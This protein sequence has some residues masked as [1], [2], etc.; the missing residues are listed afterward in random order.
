MPAAAAVRDAT[1]PWWA[2]PTATADDHD[3]RRGGRPAAAYR[4][5]PAGHVPGTLLRPGV[6]L[7]AHPDLVPRL[8]GPGPG[9]RRHHRLVPGHRGRQDAAATARALGGLAGHR[10]DDQ[11]VRPAPRLAPVRGD[12]RPGRQ[13]GDGGGDPPRVHLHRPGVRGG[14]RGDAGVPPGSAAAGPRQ[15]RV[16]AAQAAHA[17]H[18]R[19]DRGALADRRVPVAHPAGTALGAGA[20]RGVPGR[21]VR[22]AGAGAGP[23]E[24]EPLGRRRGAPGRAVPAVLPGRVGR[25]DPG[26]R[27]GVQHGTVRSGPD[28]RVRGRAGDLGAAVADLRAAGRAGARRGG[29]AVPAPVGHRPLGGG[30]PPGDGGGAGRYRDRVRADH[31]APAHLPR[32]GVGGAGGGRPGAVPARPRPLRV[33]GLRPGVAVAVARGGAAGRALPAAAARGAAALRHGG[34]AG[35]RRGRGGRRP[36][37]PGPPPGTPPPHPCN[38]HPPHPTPRPPAPPDRPR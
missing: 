7:R 34:R 12:H 15:P 24:G 14:V 30:H 21:P 19:C 26:G 9:A 6:R 5:G 32:G 11:P 20:G 36:P 1:N 22:L 33:R 8:R 13:H 3:G 38:P 29:G 16:P 37:G 28:R 23:V 27:A 17:D 25:D 4:P 18:L 31:R 35:A 10:V 2:G